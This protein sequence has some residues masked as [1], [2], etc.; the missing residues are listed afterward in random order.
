M[1]K[2][3]F[4]IIRVLFFT[5]M[6]NRDFLAEIKCKYTGIHFNIKTVSVDNGQHRGD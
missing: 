3:E 2:A 4:V 5:K 1:K 6:Q